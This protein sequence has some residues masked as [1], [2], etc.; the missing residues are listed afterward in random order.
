MD[1]VDGTSSKF[2]MMLVK[3]N[4]SITCPSEAITTNVKYI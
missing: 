4:I 3:K 1:R 2:K